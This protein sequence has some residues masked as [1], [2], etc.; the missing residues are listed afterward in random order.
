MTYKE[1]YRDAIAESHDGNQ[2]VVKAILALAEQVRGL[3][4]G[5]NYDL[6]LTP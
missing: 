3:R 4:A 6:D 2:A 1:L 5:H